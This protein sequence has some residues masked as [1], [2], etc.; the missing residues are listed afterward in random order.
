MAVAGEEGGV[1]AYALD[2]DVADR[3]WEL[4]EQLVGETF[5]LG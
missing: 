2:Q 4:S 3:L 5:N 1:E